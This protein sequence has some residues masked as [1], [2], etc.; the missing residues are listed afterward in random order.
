MVRGVEERL[1]DIRTAAADLLDFVEDM[2][3]EAFTRCRT[4]TG[5]GIER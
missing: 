1:T 5:W 4:P 2:E 3:T